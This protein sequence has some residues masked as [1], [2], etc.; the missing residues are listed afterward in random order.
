MKGVDCAL[1]DIAAITVRK[2]EHKG[3]S[4]TEARRIERP[5]RVTALACNA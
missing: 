1:V 2:S 4:G 5:G 3:E